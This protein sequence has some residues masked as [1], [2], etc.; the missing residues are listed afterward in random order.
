ATAVIQ[1]V[2]Q[3]D[4]VLAL[5]CLADATRV[6][7][8]FAT[9]AIER[10]KPALKDARPDDPVV[11]AF[12]LLA[13]DRRPRGREVFD[14][15]VERARGTTQQPSYAAA[16]AATNLKGAADVLAE[17]ARN[18]THLTPLLVK[19][20]NL[21][22]PGLSRRVDAGERDALGSLTEIGTPRA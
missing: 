4:E 7:E 13:S 8:V 19:M 12:G 15:L 21:A 18:N 22:V 16:L 10:M 17:L 2:M 3:L 9:E 5:E 1:S 6:E 11:R 20:G 14:F